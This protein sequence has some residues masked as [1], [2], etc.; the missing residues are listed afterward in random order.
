MDQ[1][2]SSGNG[3]RTH[4]A[5]AVISTPAA[6]LGEQFFK[7]HTF[8]A[9]V[10]L[11]CFLSSS[12]KWTGHRALSFSLQENIRWNAGCGLSIP[13]QV[14]RNVIS[15]GIYMFKATQFWTG[16]PGEEGSYRNSRMILMGWPF[17]L[18][19]YSGWYQE[20]LYKC[21]PSLY[22]LRKA[23]K[24]GKM[25]TFISVL[26]LS[27]YTSFQGPKDSIKWKVNISGEVSKES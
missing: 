8:K 4:I 16:M 14:D 15:T 18:F 2:W 11:F 13:F 10:F 9:R 7:A 5:G 19:S 24:Y 20:A 22:K 23:C 21:D 26:F 6:F 1:K 25:S 12:P 27:K 17:K 3:Q